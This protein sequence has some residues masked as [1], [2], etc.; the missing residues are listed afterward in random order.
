MVKTE[1]NTNLAAELQVIRFLTNILYMLAHFQR[2]NYSKQTYIYSF[3]SLLIYL[4]FMV[5]FGQR[6]AFNSTLR[7]TLL[8]N[9]RQFSKLK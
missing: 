7:P 4:F 1:K 2:N 8:K 6:F 5:S 3:I 9:C